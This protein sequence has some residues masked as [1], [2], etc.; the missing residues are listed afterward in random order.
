M[1]E[2]EIGL[3]DGGKLILINLSFSL[4]WQRVLLDLNLNAEYWTLLA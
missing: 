3:V 2:L 4:I 1:P